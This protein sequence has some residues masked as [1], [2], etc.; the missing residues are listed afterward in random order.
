MSWASPFDL[1]DPLGASTDASVWGGP[2]PRDPWG[3]IFRNDDPL[4]GSQGGTVWDTPQVSDPWPGKKDFGWETYDYRYTPDYYDRMSGQYDPTGGGDPYDALSSFGWKAIAADIDQWMQINHPELFDFNKTGSNLNSPMAS[5]G[6]DWASVDQ[7]NSAIMDAST[8]TGVPAN[9]I[10]ALMKLESNGENLA[11][12]GAGAQGPMQVVGSIWNSLG[13]DLNDPAQNIMAGATI[14]AQNYAQF[15]DW[16][17]QNGVEP[18]KAALYAYYAG[19]PY[20]LSA[21]DDPSQGGSGMSTG[22]Y[23]DQIWGTFEQLNNA[24]GGAGG[25]GGSGGFS[26]ITG[27]TVYPVTQGIGGNAI[28]YS[29]YDWTLGVHG[30]PGIDIGTPR[31]TQLYSPVGGTVIVAGGTDYFL[32]DGGGPGELRIRMDNGDQ[33]VLGHMASMNVSVGQRI[34]AGQG[35]GTS[36]TGNGGDHVHVEYLQH[37]ASTQSGFQAIDIRTALGNGTSTGT[38]STDPVGNSV[39]QIALSYV[40]KIPYPST[41][42]GNPG[43]GDDPMLYG[44]WDCSGFTYWLDQNYGTGQLPQGS[45]YQYQYAQQN[46]KLFMDTSQLQAGD[47]IFFDTGV[48]DGGGAELNNASHVAMYIGD[49]QIVHSA[50]PSVGTIVS[51]LSDYMN[52]YAFLGGMR[53]S[54]SGGGA[55]SYTGPNGAN[56]HFASSG[57]WSNFMRAAALGLPIAGAGY[58]PGYDVSAFGSWLRQNSPWMHDLP[59]FGP[60]ANPTGGAIQAP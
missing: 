54:W 20:D 35:V 34:N 59:S 50:N 24:T 56:T 53:M 19:N 43:K 60:P 2:Q 26:T 55:G 45:H 29:N 41:W 58:T 1:S 38:G 46:G 49:G 40:G 21:A 51:S 5:L 4:S 39:V 27:G 28:D 44:G 36:G 48:R 8:K 42:T 18:W 52:N 22:Q 10:K 30:H 25:G 9:L 3:G 16:A 31:G 47:L 7:W 12:N 11:P 17:T 37:G 14:L 6:G 23:G 33:V 15:K 13:F 57:N 32:D